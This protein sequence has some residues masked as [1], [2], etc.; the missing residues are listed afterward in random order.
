M[1]CPYRRSI[2]QRDTAASKRAIVLRGSRWRRQA[3]DVR[4]RHGVRQQCLDRTRAEA[5]MANVPSSRRSTATQTTRSGTKG[6]TT[7]STKASTTAR[8]TKRALATSTFIPSGEAMALFKAVELGAK[9]AK[10]LSEWLANEGPLVVQV[11]ESYPSGQQYRVHFRATNQ[12][13]H[14]MYLLS[15]EL[16]WPQA[17]EP[18]ALQKPPERRIGWGDETPPPLVPMPMPAHVATARQIEFCIAFPLP[19]R[20][21]MDTGLWHKRIGRM[22]LMFQV[23]DSEKTTPKVVT[24]AI[25]IA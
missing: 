10:A 12:T 4:T 14:G 9:G 20:A 8:A 13:M 3:W 16:E 23:L 17:I 11:L 25:V 21:D 18:L 5:I 1:M 19:S 15:A 22:R 2:V 7:A 6:S 24:F